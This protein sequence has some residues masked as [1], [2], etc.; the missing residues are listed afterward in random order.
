MGWPVGHVGQ[1][2]KESAY[3]LQ[4]GVTHADVTQNRP[5]ACAND[6]RAA[7]RVGFNL[8]CKLRERQTERES[9]RQGK[10]LTDRERETESVGETERATDRE[11]QIE[12]ARETESEGETESDR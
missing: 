5:A 8:L 1:C 2:V 12:R 7:F 3:S 10:R 11:G 6:Q 9:D 4:A